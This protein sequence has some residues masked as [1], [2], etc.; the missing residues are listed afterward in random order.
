M[1]R[2]EQVVKTKVNVN[3]CYDDGIDSN[4]YNDV[5]DE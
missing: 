1:I 2:M 5:S 4:D 3:G